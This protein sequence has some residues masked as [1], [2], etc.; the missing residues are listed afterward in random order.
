MLIIAKKLCNYHYFI[1]FLLFLSKSGRTDESYW[2][3]F[4][5]FLSKTSVAQFETMT[6]HVL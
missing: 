2:S 4:L 1:L 3:N 5:R 6:C